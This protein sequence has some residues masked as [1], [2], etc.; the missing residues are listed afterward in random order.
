MMPLTLRDRPSTWAW[1]N[2]GVL[3]RPPR[4]ELAPTAAGWAPS[5][6]S[7][8]LSLAARTPTPSWT[9]RGSTTPGAASRTNNIQPYLA[10]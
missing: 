10:V 4:V 6:R 5:C 2:P 3:H 1:R 7:C 8:W 9:W